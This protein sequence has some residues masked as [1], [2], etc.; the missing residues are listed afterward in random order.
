MD[1][2]EL[3]GTEKKEE[4]VLAL[5]QKGKAMSDSLFGCFNNWPIPSAANEFVKELMR[6]MGRFVDVEKKIEHDQTPL[7]LSVQFGN[8]KAVSNLIE[9]CANPRA[10]DRNWRT[11]LHF[12]AKVGSKSLCALFLQHGCKINKVTRLG[13]TA[14]MMA[15]ANGREEVVQ[16]LLENHADT[17]IKDL[18]GKSALHLATKD[19]AD[20][21]SAHEAE[22]RSGC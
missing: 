5:R 12:A 13:E 3:L 21:I 17:K 1:P 2:D 8:E 10:V 15:A 22:T 16:F 11:A 4:I 7:H 19:C 9:R 20:I 18:F 14:L 6:P